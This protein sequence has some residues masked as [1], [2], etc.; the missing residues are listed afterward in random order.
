MKGK[1]KK[2]LL[3]VLLLLF[4]T[5][6][7]EFKLAIAILTNDQLYTI[8]AIASVITMTLLLDL[9]KKWKLA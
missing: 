8:S 7:R 4:G 3:P 6:L 5:A 9:V 2:F 1:S